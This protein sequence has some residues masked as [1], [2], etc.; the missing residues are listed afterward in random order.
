M[1]W[2][3]HEPV[4]HSYF[5]HSCI[6]ELGPSVNMHCVFNVRTLRKI[7]KEP[8]MAVCVKIN[9]RIVYRIVQVA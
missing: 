3:G 5:I 6:S 7:W 4:S 9:T 8:A 2:L 1:E